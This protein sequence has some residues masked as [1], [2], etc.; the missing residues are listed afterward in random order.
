MLALL[1][2]AAGTVRADALGAFPQLGARIPASPGVPANP[3]TDDHFTRWKAQIGPAANPEGKIG[4]VLYPLGGADVQ[5]GFAAFTNARGEAPRR[6]VIV[7]AFPF[8]A[9]AEVLRTHA[10]AQLKQGFYHGRRSDTSYIWS[11]EFQF[12]PRVTGPAILWEL[13]QMGARNVSVSYLDRRGRPT[14]PPTR[15]RGG[16]QG[17]P[18]GLA[19]YDVHDRDNVEVT[20]EVGG[21]RRSVL[22]VQQDLTSA[23]LPPVLRNVIDGGYDGYL[24]K[25]QY[26]FGTGTSFRAFVDRA[27]KGLDPEHGVILSD[28]GHTPIRA[29]FVP[30]DVPRIKFGYGG[31]HVHRATPAARLPRVPPRVR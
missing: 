28:Q 6:L 29:G 8:G 23:D 19:Y 30:V 18:S 25:A 27:Q 21:Q 15:D 22:Y 13:E 10:N 16:F 2:S 31:P 12:G 9:P 20:F 24:Q 4:T 5:G 14:A 11:A 3:D 26:L 1:A 7:D 17:G